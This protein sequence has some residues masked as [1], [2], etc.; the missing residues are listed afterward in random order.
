MT[1]LI[2]TFIVTTLANLIIP[3]CLSADLAN[4][5][6]DENDNNNDNYKDGNNNNNIFKLFSFRT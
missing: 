3:I 1:D 5:K 4:Y 2:S 6:D